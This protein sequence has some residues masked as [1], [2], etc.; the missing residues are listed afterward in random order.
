VQQIAKVGFFLDCEADMQDGTHSLDLH[1][2]ILLVLPGRLCIPQHHRSSARR[3]PFT[4][5]QGTPYV[6]VCGTIDTCKHALN[7]TVMLPVTSGA[8]VPAGGEAL[9]QS[10]DDQLHGSLW[11]C[12]CCQPDQR[13]QARHRGT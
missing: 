8:C 9:W 5:M 1:A 7:H 10:H 2:C 6:H 13:A 11:G 3:L 12:W 4:H